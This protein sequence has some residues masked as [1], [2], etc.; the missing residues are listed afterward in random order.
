MYIV[1][2]KTSTGEKLELKF[3]QT[4]D[5][6]LLSQCIDFTK[7]VESFNDWQKKMIDEDIDVLSTEYMAGY[8]KRALHAIKEF[9]GSSEVDQ[10]KTGKFYDHLLS[11]IDEKEKD[12]DL[13]TW[14]DTVT[15][16]YANCFKLIANYV[17]PLPTDD[18]CKFECA[19]FE[20]QIPSTYRDA[21]T[22][23][24]VFESI[25]SG[26]AIEALEVMRAYNNNIDNDPNGSIRFT[27]ILKL[28]ALFARKIENG[29][30]EEFPTTEAEIKKL[31]DERIRIFAPALKMT[32]ALQI[33]G[34]F[35]RGTKILATTN[36]AA[37]SSNH[38]NE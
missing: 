26:Q 37:S 38:Q 9:T 8:L 31:I 18:T 21:L 16:L 27:S 29:V 10:L 5:D 20:W 24:I 23:Q 12:L 34:F 11:L 36:A 19:G 35:L 2:L 13:Q 30:K 22:G 4:A 25:P 7:A 15:A 33:E 14:D 17:P 6:I 1:E 28:V 32:H 3:P